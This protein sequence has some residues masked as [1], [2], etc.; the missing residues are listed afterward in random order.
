[1]DDNWVAAETY[2]ED[3]PTINTCGATVHQRRNEAVI[4]EEISG[5]FLILITEKD[6]PM[7]ILHT[8]GSRYDS[9]IACREAAEE[10]LSNHPNGLS[11]VDKVT[12]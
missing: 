7:K 1:M 3:R 9:Y 11:D 8:V 4:L 2:Y 12:P 6:N 10:W 5:N